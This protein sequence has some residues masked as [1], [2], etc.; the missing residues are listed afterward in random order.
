LRAVVVWLFAALAAAT[1]TLI[2]GQLLARES[3]I[4]SKD[5]HSLRA[6]GVTSGQI[7]ALGVLRV[8]VIGV[9]G[10]FGAVGIAVL[11]SP[12]GPLG[13]ARTAEP[14]P[15]FSADAVVLL[16]GGLALIAGVTSMGAIFTW[17]RSRD[18]T[19]RTGVERAHP[20][21]IPEA[22]ARASFRPSAV[23]GVRMAVETGSGPTAMPVRSTTTGLAIAVGA[24]TVAIVFG[25]SLHHLLET[26]RLFGFTWDVSGGNPFGPDLSRFV[27][28]LNASPAVGAYFSGTT[29]LR[30][31]IIG[32]RRTD[33]PVWGLEQNKGDV[34]PAVVDG[35]WARSP[36]EIVLG[37]KIMRRVGAHI[38]GLVRV[39]GEETGNVVPVTMRV[40]GQ[41]VFP[42]EADETGGAGPG[43]AVGMTFQ[44]LQRL[45]PDAPRNVFGIR[46]AA[47]VPHSQGLT[48]VERIFNFESPPAGPNQPSDLADLARVDGTPVVLAG[49]MGLLA[50]ATLAH[51]VVATTRRRAR[52]LAILK[53]LGFTRGQ[54]SSTMLWQA[55][56]LALAGLI[57]AIPL[58]VSIGRWSWTLISRGLGFVPEPATR[59]S[60]LLSVPPLTIIAALIVG[61]VAAAPASRTRAAVILRTE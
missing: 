32:S 29:I 44:A 42:T 45:V 33:A 35:R 22:L 25:S 48:A 50:V 31:N 38:G 49:L 23:A 41:G 53:T 19:T 47:G 28:P 1:V 27:E 10:A 39:V 6:V 43:E 57:V 9:A 3:F 26:P 2:A 7:V 51:T 37:S 36:D 16:L 20:S 55:G 5:D 34:A 15:G 52:D 46:F 13:A 54:L 21:W 14:S 11:L 60:L 8:L 30:A 58:G 4:S 17:M 24:L 56:A 18:V 59:L 12:L 61:A 40:V